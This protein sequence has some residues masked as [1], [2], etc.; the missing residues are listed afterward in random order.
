[1]DFTMGSGDTTFVKVI[2]VPFVKASSSTNLYLTSKTFVPVRFGGKESETT[3]NITDNGQSESVAQLY[4]LAADSFHTVITLPIT[5]ITQSIIFHSLT[6]CT[7]IQ[8]TGYLCMKDYVPS[9]TS[10]YYIL[11]VPPWPNW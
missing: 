4:R 9:F 1:M 3:H 8:L 2:R 11:R 5:F 7:A 10:F 6:F